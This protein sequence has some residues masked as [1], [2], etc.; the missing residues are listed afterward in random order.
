MKQ[1]IKRLNYLLVKHF[2]IP[3]RQKKLP[4]PVDALIATIL[5]QNTNDKNSYQAY[6]N[7]K[8]K[9]KVWQEVA[10]AP[11]YKIENAIKVAGL[12]KQKSAAIKNFFNQLKKK[13]GRLNLNYI[14]KLNDKDILNHLTSI[15]GIGIKTASCVLLFSLDRNVCPVDTHVHRTLNRIGLV[16][17][18]SP[19]KTFYE[20]DGHLSDGTAHQFHT[21][22]IK[23]GKEI[24]K[25]QK[26]LCSVCPLLKTCKFKKKN[27][28]KIITRE[29]ENFLLLDSI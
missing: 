25:A 5:S 2:G 8:K 16:R 9:F 7:L 14:K 13:K 4:N 6:K 21:N 17:T 29:S 23:L 26:P 28:A 27:L 3:D 19:E 18:A 15:N 1:Q 24:C 20:I 22:L 12:G 11:R 10:D